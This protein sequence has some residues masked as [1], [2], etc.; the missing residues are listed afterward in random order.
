[1]YKE[2]DLGNKRYSDDEIF[3]LLVLH[4]DIIQRPIVE[5]GSKAIL[6]RPPEKVTRLFEN[7]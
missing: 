6:A 5:Y 4:P 3:D 2:L 7:K 1:M